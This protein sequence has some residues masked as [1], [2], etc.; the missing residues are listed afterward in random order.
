M[1][2]ALETLIEMGFDKQLSELAVKRAGNLDSAIEWIDKN[3]DKLT[4]EQITAELADA[5]DNE[6]APALKPGE[7]ARSLV[8]DTCQRK[9]R[10]S[11]QAEFHATKTGHQEFS[12]S[13]EEIAPLTEEEKKA[14]L[15]E[16][17]ERLAAKRATQSDQDAIDRKKN[18]QIRMKS[19]K[20]TQEAKENLEKKERL[21]EA[22]AKKAEKQADIDA[23]KRVLAKLEADKAER[24]RKAEVERA[25]RA[26][27]APPPPAPEPAAPTT[28]GPVLSKPA[29]AYAETRLALQTPGGRVQKNFPVETTLFEV[30]HALGQDGVEVSSFTQNFPKKVYDKT[31]FG[32]TLKEA[33]MV[34]SAALI[35]K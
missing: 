25:Q 1:S 12:E 10:S 15:E 28:S 22:A 6:E 11:A 13:T 23:K 21:K 2:S 4:P 3:Q 24:K 19:T 30:A 14:R 33:G 32:M 17:R 16:L 8:C 20:E 29:S 18:E 5:E 35:V 9:V 34:P 7:E 31:D 27:Q 26:G